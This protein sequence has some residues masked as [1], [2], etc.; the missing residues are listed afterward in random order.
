MSPGSS[1]MARMTNN[2][3]TAATG[4]PFPVCLSLP[5]I[6]SAEDERQA[7]EMGW[8]V[9]DRQ[10]DRPLDVGAGELGIQVM[11]Y[12]EGGCA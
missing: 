9:A 11:S 6:L 10:Q 4:S 2:M 1:C 7:R 12:S 5:L 3:N 8:P